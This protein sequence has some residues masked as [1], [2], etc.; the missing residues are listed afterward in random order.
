[1]SVCEVK[2]PMT[3]DPGTLKPKANGLL[4]PRMGICDKCVNYSEVQS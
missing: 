1:M 2:H 3:F 4:D